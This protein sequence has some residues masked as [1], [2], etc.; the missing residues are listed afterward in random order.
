MFL[1]DTVSKCVCSGL[2]KL[3]NY[4]AAALWCHGVSAFCFFVFQSFCFPSFVSSLLS[5]CLPGVRLSQISA[6][7]HVEA[8]GD[9]LYQKSGG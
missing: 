7:E 2:Q 4:P 5:V 6:A 9:P 8:F 1:H 3:I